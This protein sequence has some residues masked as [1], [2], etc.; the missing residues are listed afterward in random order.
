MESKIHTVCSQC[1]SPCCG[2]QERDR[3]FPSR[4]KH[5]QGDCAHWPTFHCASGLQSPTSAP[6]PSALAWPVSNCPRNDL[7]TELIIVNKQIITFNNNSLFCLMYV[8]LLTFI[9][10]IITFEVKLQR[11]VLFFFLNL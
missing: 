2:V 1:R 10:L 8:T 4:D 5:C 3:S 11:I 9:I 7:Q 6:L